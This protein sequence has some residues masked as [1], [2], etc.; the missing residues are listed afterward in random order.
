MI[1]YEKSEVTLGASVKPH[2]SLQVSSILNMKTVE[3]H[4]KYLGLATVAGRPKKEL[5]S[6]IKERVRKKLSGW[7][8]RNM[9]AAAR[10]VLIKSVAQAQL[11]YAMSVFRVLEGV[12]DEVHGMIMRFWWGQKGTEKRIPWLAREK[13]VCPKAEGGIGFRDLRGF[14]TALL[15]LLL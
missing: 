2:Q 3:K 1:S 4:D 15:A 11:T 14:N 6:T 12:I 10:E 5:F 7:K 8:E 9:S 13:L